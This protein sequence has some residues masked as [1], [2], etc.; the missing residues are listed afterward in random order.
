MMGGLS[1]FYAGELLDHGLLSRA[2]L[3]G[4][5]VFWILR[6]GAQWFVYD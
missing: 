6:L 5:G 2:I 1:V 3:T 4:F